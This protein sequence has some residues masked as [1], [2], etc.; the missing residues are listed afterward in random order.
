MLLQYNSDSGYFSFMPANT[1]AVTTVWRLRVAN[2]WVVPASGL[3][4]CSNIL[5]VAN[6]GLCPLNNCWQ[7]DVT[8]ESGQCLGGYCDRKDLL[9]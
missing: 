2:V 9:Q 5:T 6:L 7:K 1:V 4:Y 3:S 8:F